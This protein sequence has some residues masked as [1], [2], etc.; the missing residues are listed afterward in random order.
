MKNILVCEFLRYRKAAVLAMAAFLIAAIFISRLGP[1]LDPNSEPVAVLSVA[2]MFGSMAFGLTQMLL[3]RRKNHWT[4][5]IHRPVDPQKIY[6]AVMLA[7]MAVL[8]I[9]IAVPW[10]LMVAGLDLATA[11]VIESRHYAYVVHFYLVCCAAYL[12]GSLTALSANKGSFLFA[13]LILILLIPTPQTA[14]GQFL[15][16]ILMVVLLAV[17][18]AASF[19]PNLSQHI[20]KPWAIALMAVPLSVSVMY[21]LTMS[22]TMT[23]HV[24]KFVLG[25]HPDNNPIDGT[26]RYYWNL[27]AADR[28]DYSLQGSSHPRAAQFGQ[29]AALADAAIVSTKAAPFPHR[30]QL[31]VEDQQYA[32]ADSESNTVWQFSHSSMLLEGRH[33]ISQ[34]PAGAV[35]RNG[36]LDT[37]DQARA[38]DRFQEVPIISGNNLM[39]TSD[40]M[41]FVDFN[42]RH[43]IEKFQ[44]AAAERIIGPPQIE[45]HYVALSTSRSLLLFDRETFADEYYAAEPDHIVPHPVDPNSVYYVQTYR[46]VD[47]YLVVYSG[48]DLLAFDTPGIIVLHSK[49]GGETEQIYTRTFD[50]YA[51]PGWIRHH[52]E[53]AAPVLSVLYDKMVALIDPRT[54][55]GRPWTAERMVGYP[56][57]LYGVA[58]L[59]HLIAIAAVVFLVRRQNMPKAVA[60]TWLLL[61]AFLGLPIVI[62]CLLMNPWRPAETEPEPEAEASAAPA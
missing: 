28:V 27:D 34:D 51:H 15:P 6:G 13:P 20:R 57:V 61:V 25:T 2:L 46:M 30:G 56:P 38:E 31:F 17:L 32:L 62:A 33:A 7:G 36:F 5:L 8:A 43:L 55:D 47:G 29:Q 16:S 22:S 42:E 11:T 14:L 1:F 53:M 35:G 26:F 48:P 3:H 58:A 12:V 10:V 50:T 52:L 49:P 45:E 54:T 60:T 59:L 37:V 40:R 9:A 23:Y 18:N 44:P 21:G 41:Y 24:P 39:V 4:F 19:K